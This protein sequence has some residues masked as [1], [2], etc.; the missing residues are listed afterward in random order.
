[1]V[2]IEIMERACDGRWQSEEESIT[3]RDKIKRRPSRPPVLSRLP[4]LC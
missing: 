1:M 4:S 3:A 2:R